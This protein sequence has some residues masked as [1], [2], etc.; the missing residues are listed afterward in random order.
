M[1]LFSS[2]CDDW[3]FNQRAVC[4]FFP[5]PIS[6]LIGQPIL[7]FRLRSPSYWVL[8]TFHLLLTN[9]WSSNCLEDS[10]VPNWSDTFSATKT[11]VSKSPLIDIFFTKSVRIF[12]LYY[13]V[14]EAYVQGTLRS[15]FVYLTD[16]YL[17]TISLQFKQSV[18]KYLHQ[19]FTMLNETNENLVWNT[20][21][22][23]HIYEGVLLMI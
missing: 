10:T 23:Q 2:S 4:F 19:N 5:F 1:L 17:P 18:Y 8:M 22:W 14:T 16:L 20:F 6:F 13:C 15:R 11:P 3:Y 21:C 12:N 9:A 7:S